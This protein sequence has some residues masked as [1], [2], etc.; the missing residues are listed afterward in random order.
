MVSFTVQ[1]LVSLIKSHW[2][3]F[4]LFLLL[5][6]TNLRK[7]LYGCKFSLGV[8]LCFMF[9]SLSDFEFVYLFI[10]CLFRAALEAHGSSQ[11]RGRIGATAASLHHRHK[12]VESEP[13][14]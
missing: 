12:N 7:H 4:V 2:F 5:W 8:L 9:E 10:F 3:I 6:E 14:L 1:K 13:S 11:A